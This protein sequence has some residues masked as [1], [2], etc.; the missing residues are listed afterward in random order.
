MMNVY[1][2]FS[3]CQPHHT[4]HISVVRTTVLTITTAC[5][6]AISIPVLISL[7]FLHKVTHR[8]AR[9]SCGWW[10]IKKCWRSEINCWRS[11]MNCW[12]S[13]KSC[14]YTIF[15][16][17]TE[18]FWWSAICFWQGESLAS[19][20]WLTNSAKYLARHTIGIMTVV[21]VTSLTNLTA[22]TCLG[23]T[24]LGAFSVTAT[25]WLLTRTLS[26]PTR[27]PAPL[28]RTL[29]STSIVL[30]Q[31]VEL[32]SPVCQVLLSTYMRNAWTQKRRFAPCD[33]D[34]SEEKNHVDEVE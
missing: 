29:T 30:V 23:R 1:R 22:E 19:S 4:V 25:S 18:I 9:F 13:E 17:A 27:R 12:W 26:R 6:T 24:F 5:S 31:K 8:P 34:L 28:T 2:R 10:S 14:T 33:K 11:E 20:F 32:G 7:H 16:K 21:Y 15:V 3:N